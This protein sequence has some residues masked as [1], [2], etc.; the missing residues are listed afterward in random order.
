MSQCHHENVVTYYT[1]FVVKDELW[2]IM[3]LLDGGSLLDVLKHRMKTLNCKHGVLDEA[4][5]ATVLKEVLKG[6]EYFHANGHIHRDVKAGNILLALDG[7][8]QI[9][10]FG[11]SA[12]ISS[13]GDLTRD[14]VKHTFVG[15]PCWMAPEIMEQRTCGYDTK[16]DIWSLGIT[17]IELATGTAPYHKFPP[18][19]VLV[20]TLDN[21]PPTLDT[22][23]DD[24]DQYK[25]YSKTFRKLI[26]ECLKKDPN[27][28]PTAKQLLK[29]EFFKKAKDKP[30]IVK[31]L[32]LNSEVRN[33]KIKRNI[34]VPSVLKRDSRRWKKGDDGEWI[35]GE[36]DNEAANTN[37]DD[38]SDS[39]DDDN[40]NNN[41]QKTIHC[42]NKSKQQQSDGSS[43]QLHND[44]TIAASS[45]LNPNNKQNNN[46]N[47]NETSTSTINSN[48]S[49]SSSSSQPLQLPSSIHL[50]LRI[51]DEK[52]DL[53]DIKF[54]FLPNKDTVEEISNELVNAKLIDSQDMTVGK[55]I[56]KKQKKKLKKII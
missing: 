41:D 18:M 39:S 42:D 53:Q 31:H 1:S 25:E 50:V 3:K 5:I 43:S 19:K 16:V 30:F 40:N 27:E 8:V 54:D 56:N 52:K 24:K 11:V 7:S 14:K 32:A 35:F 37:D 33:A 46:N 12:F 45:T 38:D 34:Q 26:A 55:L 48:N 28:R 6:L 44:E 15:T 17:A 21:D 10:D 51:R 4:S 20:M 23:V 22:C 13:G 2:L 9:A 29:H 47:S 36:S 49:S